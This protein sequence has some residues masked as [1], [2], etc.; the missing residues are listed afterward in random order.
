MI[1]FSGGGYYYVGTLHEGIPVAQE[2][3]KY[4]YNAFVLK[5]RVDGEGNILM[6]MNIIYDE[7]GI[8]KEECIKPAASIIAYTYF[9]DNPKFCKNDAPAFFIVGKNDNIDL[10]KK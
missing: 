3:N 7:A 4:G 9:C 5:Y 10:G 8:K 1:M 2:I 6:I